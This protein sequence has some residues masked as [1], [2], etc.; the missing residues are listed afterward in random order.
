[1]RHTVLVLQFHDRERFDI[2]LGLSEFFESSLPTSD[3][4][5]NGY[6]LSLRVNAPPTVNGLEEELLLRE[7]E[8]LARK[9][10]TQ[11]MDELKLKNEQL[12]EYNT[13]LEKMVAARTAELQKAYEK[14]KS[15]LETAADYVR[16]LIPP[17]CETPVAIRWK[18]APSADLGGDIFGYHSI[19]SDHLAVYLLDVT[20]HGVDSAL[21]AVSIVN[22]I[23]STSLPGVD[24]RL[25]ARVLGALNNAF[26]MELFGDKMFTMWYGVFNVRT[27]VL[28]W[29]N[30]GH[31]DA[32]LYRYDAANLE[33]LGSL[34]PML[35]MIQDVEFEEA[36][37]SINSAAR[38]FVY[39]DGAHEIQQSDGAYWSY[40]DFI[41]YMLEI[42]NCDD[43]LQVLLDHVKNMRGSARLDDD[44]S[45]IEVNF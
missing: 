11:L 12:E 36:E 44:F 23:R 41:Q 25:P 29:S 5:G 45:A 17:P 32:L 8:R 4:S 31:P 9:T 35:G 27:R 28:R 19:D 6:L 34:G 33:R 22:V 30:G 13:Q 42:A 43:A 10:R 1:D 39:S 40:D 26:P 3:P 18:Y 21:L 20:G 16:R 2:V 38:L 14:I 37:S 7:R 24:F 15:D